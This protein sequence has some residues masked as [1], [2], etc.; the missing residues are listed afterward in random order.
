MFKELFRVSLIFLCRG[1]LLRAFLYRALVFTPE[2]KLKVGPL[3]SW[4]G[5]ATLQD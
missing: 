2:E 1:P 4:A 3:I 5:L